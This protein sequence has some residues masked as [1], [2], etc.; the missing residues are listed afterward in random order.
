M[1]L[2]MIY[3][4]ALLLFPSERILVSRGLQTILRS[5]NDCANAP[6]P[7]QSST[8]TPTPTPTPMPPRGLSP[9]RIGHAS[10]SSRGGTGGHYRGGHQFTPRGGPRCDPAVQEELDISGT[11]VGIISY[12]AVGWSG[13]SKLVISGNEFT[14]SQDDNKLVG[15][16]AATRTCDYSAVALRFNE[17]P[18]ADAS[19]ETMPISVSLRAAK[20]GKRLWLISVP[21]E[22]TEFTFKPSGRNIWRWLRIWKWVP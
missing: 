9:I 1:L 13:E 14:L 21:G 18:G 17:A 19:T 12:P 2:T 4:S 15:Q 7:L 8:P 6:N 16:I 10:V 5:G 11:Y 3:I 20:E 22:P